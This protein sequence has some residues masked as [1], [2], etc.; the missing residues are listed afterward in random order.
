MKDDNPEMDML[1]KSVISILDEFDSQL[2][3]YIKNLAKKSCKNL[4]LYE[5]KSFKNQN[6]FIFKLH[7]ELKILHFKRHLNQFVHQ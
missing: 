3:D 1:V 5:L 6:H 4:K 7:Q 2:L